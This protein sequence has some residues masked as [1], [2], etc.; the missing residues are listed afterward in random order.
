MS[1][2]AYKSGDFAIDPVPVAADVVIAQGDLISLEGGLATVANAAADNLT[3]IGVSNEKHTTGDPAG[4]IGVYRL[5]PSSVFEADLDAATDITVNDNLAWATGQ[6]VTKSATDAIAR[7]AE[8]KTGATKI[9]LR[10]KLPVTLIGDL[11]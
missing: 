3:I 8:T 4:T 9:C 1:G 5:L 6:K 2:F 10:F 7:A 11:S